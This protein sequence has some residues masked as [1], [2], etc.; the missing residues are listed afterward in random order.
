MEIAYNGIYLS[1][2]FLVLLLIAALGRCEADD[3]LMHSIGSVTLEQYLELSA[4][5][6]NVESIHP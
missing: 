6:P 2:T 5:L 4:F 3:A 1:V